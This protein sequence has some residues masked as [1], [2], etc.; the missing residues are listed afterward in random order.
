M[1]DVNILMCC[2]YSISV[3]KLNSFCFG[4]IVNIYNNSDCYSMLI[5]LTMLGLLVAILLITLFQNGANFF[6][7]YIFQHNIS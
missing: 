7:P 2:I 4:K 6:T 3:P 1:D 5:F